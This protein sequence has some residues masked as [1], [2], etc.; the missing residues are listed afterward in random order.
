MNCFFMLIKNKNIINM[1]IIIFVI[2]F[3]YEF[4]PTYYMT[5][6]A[7]AKGYEEIQKIALTLINVSSYPSE[8]MPDLAEWQLAR[9]R[10][11]RI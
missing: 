3:S 9:A 10:A 4:G 6:K 5:Y 1:I 2:I 11:T 8:L 7:N